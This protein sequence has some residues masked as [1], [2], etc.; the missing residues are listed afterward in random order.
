MAENWNEF[1]L[2]TGEGKNG[3]FVEAMNLTVERMTAML[4]QA[5][6]PYSGL[7]PESLD[8][9][10]NA[11][12][13]DRGNVS[14]KDVISDAVELVAKNSILVQHPHCIAHLHTPPLVSAVAAEV[15]IAMLNQSMDSWDQAS[16]ATYVEQ[17]V[18]DWACGRFGLDRFEFVVKR[19]LFD[20]RLAQ[21][22]II[23]DNQYGARGHRLSPRQSSFFAPF[24]AAR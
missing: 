4:G 17:K 5:R 19:Q 3:G 23:V 9:M 2:H 8:D 6:S 7:D 18:V 16:A 13:L 1:F 12:D 15:I 20:K 24:P 22:G 11:V 10:I 14:L 21:F